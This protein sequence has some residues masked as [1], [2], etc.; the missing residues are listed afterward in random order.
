MVN[1]I[2]NEL[3]KIYWHKK[4]TYF[5]LF[6]CLM[7]FLPLLFAFISS[8]KIHDGQT[9]PLFFVGIITS[10]L[11]PVFITVLVSEM[12]TDEYVKGNF[13][14]TLIHP[15]SRTKLLTAKAAA[16][17]L[18]INI[19]LAVSLITGYG[20][21]TLLFGWGKEFVDHGVVYTTREGIFMTLGYYFY[22]SLPLISFSF[23][24][25]LLA[26]IFQNSG[27][28]VG[29]TLGATFAAIILGLLVTE[30]QPYLINTYFTGLP[31]LLLSEAGLNDILRP[32]TVIFLYAFIP[33]LISLCLL[34]RRDILH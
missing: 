29:I 33:Y 6:I 27:L 28:V 34:N 23:P 32:V 20:I 14:V 3:L 5:L 1:L 25:I 13:A 10:F 30:I 17:F 8:M 15:V 16:L 7:Q 2:K 26:L 31:Q 11:L 12:I 24:V 4:L 18:V 9:Y 21:G 19:V 22:A